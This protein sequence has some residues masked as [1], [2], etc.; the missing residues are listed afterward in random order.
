MSREP[1]FE[2]VTLLLRFDFVLYHLDL[3]SFLW[4]H[5]SSFWASKTSFLNVTISFCILSHV[6]QSL[7]AFAL[8]W[9]S[10]LYFSCCCFPSISSRS[11]A[12]C[13]LLNASEVYCFLDGTGSTSSTDFDQDLP[14]LNTK[15]LSLLTASLAFSYRIPLWWSREGFSRTSL[16][17]A[18]FTEIW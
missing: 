4:N 15:Q 9:R 12:V 18:M 16:P 13:S 2:T 11:W 10:C 6:S 17:A 14:L 7:D 5:F 1:W 8:L 3:L